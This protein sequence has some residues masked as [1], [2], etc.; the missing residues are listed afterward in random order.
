[1]SELIYYQHGRRTFVK[2]HRYHTVQNLCRNRVFKNE[3]PDDSHWCPHG[4]P[5]G[6]AK[7]AQKVLAIKPKSK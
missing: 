5:H 2:K 1:M 6:N 7:L 3:P 4:P